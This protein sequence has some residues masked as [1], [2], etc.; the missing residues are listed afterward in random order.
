MCVF[1]QV[2]AQKPERVVDL[3]VL[4]L[5][6]LVMSAGAGAGVFG[7]SS[8]MCTAEPLP[9]LS[10]LFLHFYGNMPSSKGITE[11]TE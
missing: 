6:A 10:S 7:K 5:R 4:R 2:S 3:L 8:A 9:P 1:V 11:E